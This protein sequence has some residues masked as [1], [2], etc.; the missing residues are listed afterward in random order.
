MRLS[1]AHEIACSEFVSNFTFFVSD[2]R[3]RVKSVNRW[4]VLRARTD[5]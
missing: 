3:K 2:S 4:S 5:S 1:Q